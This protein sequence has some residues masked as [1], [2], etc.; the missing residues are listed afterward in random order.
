MP[1][2]S[3]TGQKRISFSGKNQ[4][5]TFGKEFLAWQLKEAAELKSEDQNLDDFDLRNNQNLS[6]S[7]KKNF[8]DEQRLNELVKNFEAKNTFTF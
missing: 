5:D 1:E 4:L 2:E 3:A 7:L 8:E 6:S